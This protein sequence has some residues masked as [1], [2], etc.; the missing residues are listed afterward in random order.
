MAEYD[1]FPAGAEN[2]GFDGDGDETGETI[3]MKEV[4]RARLNSARRDSKDTGQSSHEEYAETSFG[5]DI[6]EITP[7]TQRERELNDSGDIIKSKLPNADTSKLISKIDENG[8]VLVKLIRKDGKYHPLFNSDG[9]VNKK[10]PTA[11]I[12]AL[13]EPADKI[14]EA[15][16]DEIARREKK[17]I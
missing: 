14:T 9:E 5:G 8:R 6:S 2:P 11:I 7:L 10:L 3:E 15:N 1:P 12:R 13:G 17:I 16:K 4:D